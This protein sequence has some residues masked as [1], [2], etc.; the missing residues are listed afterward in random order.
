MTPSKSPNAADGC[1]DGASEVSPAKEKAMPLLSEMRSRAGSSVFGRRALRPRSGDAAG[2]VLRRLRNSI[3]SSVGQ[4]ICDMYHYF[5]SAYSAWL[6]IFSGLS[7][8]VGLQA[9]SD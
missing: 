2:A 5:M 3:T 7:P 6:A 4:C 1:R 8:S 9:V